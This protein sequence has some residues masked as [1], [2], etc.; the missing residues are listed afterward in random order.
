VGK[1]TLA[2][3]L[4]RT[5]RI[6]W[7]PT[8]IRTVLGRVLP[9]LDAVDTDPVDAVR[10]AELMYPHIEQAVEVCA[11]EA[12]RFLIEGFELAPSYPQRLRRAARHHGSGLLPRT[13]HVLPGRSGLLPRPG[14]L[15]LECTPRSTLSVCTNPRATLTVVA[16]ARRVGL[17]PDTIRC[18]ER[19][20]VLVGGSAD[21][22]GVR[23]PL[24]ARLVHLVARSPNHLN[25]AVEIV[26]L[27]HQ[28]IVLKRRVTRPGLRDRPIIA[29]LSRT[30]PRVRWSSFLVSPKP[31]GHGRTART[32]FQIGTEPVDLIVTSLS[33][34]CLG[35][36]RARQ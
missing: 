11:Q 25:S 8:V 15:I 4:L 21:A 13:L 18:Y 2:Q 36:S 22:L 33:M 30:F 12:Q 5:D 26:V 3:M 6:H 28:S 20:G 29:A 14:D 19:I 32:S 17:R 9:E 35:I 31:A 27:R 16:L 7:L 23:V 24:V 1:S 34:I 10:P